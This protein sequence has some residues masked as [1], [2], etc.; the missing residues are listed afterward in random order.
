MVAK[1]QPERRDRRGHRA[2]LRFEVAVAEAH[3]DLACPRIRGSVGFWEES[4][5]LNTYTC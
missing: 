4:G 5:A 1:P 2:R 3:A